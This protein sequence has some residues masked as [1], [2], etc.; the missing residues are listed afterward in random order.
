MLRAQSSSDQRNEILELIPVRKLWGDLPP[1]LV[2]GHIHWLDLSTKIMEIRPLKQLWETSP[3]NWRIDCSSDQYYLHRGHETLLDVYSPT[4][5][6]ISKCFECLNDLQ[7]ERILRETM[8]M[9]RSRRVRNV[10]ITTSPIDIQSEP[11]QPQSALRL[12][13]TLPHYDLSFFVN[14][15]EELES[16]DFKGMV[17]DENQCVEALFG[18][19]NLLVL[20]PK[21]NHA[22]AESLIPRRVIIPNGKLVKHDDDQ[23]RVDDLHIYHQDD[24]PLFHTYRVDTELGCLMGDGSMES[25]R[26]LID[27]HSITSCHRPDPLTAKTG[28]QTALSLVESTRCRAVTK[29]DYYFYSLNTNYPQ[30]NA[31]HT[32]IKNRYYWTDPAGPWLYQADSATEK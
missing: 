19:E 21:T 25:T 24:K 10:L 3:E 23:V 13:V 2:D 28:A 6:M 15:R 12:S 11:A 4:W 16:C 22:G 27:L 29:Y 14:D 30:V 17:C 20:R 5:A 7:V 31:A 26:H 18:L 32:Q 8:A 9:E 1:A